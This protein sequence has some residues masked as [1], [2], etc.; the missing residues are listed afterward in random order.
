MEKF[1]IVTEDS[2]LHKEYWQYR[3]WAE[4]AHKKAKEF[5]Q[6]HNIET[7][8]YGLLGQDIYIKPTKKDSSVLK[9]VLCLP[10]RGEDGFCR[11]RNNS[12]I[13]RAWN[14]ILNQNGIKGISKPSAAMYFYSS[15]RI[16]TRL[17]DIDGVLYCSYEN[18]GEVRNPK[19]MIEIPASQFFKVIE[20]EKAKKKSA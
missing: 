16:R 7:K 9:N 4:I 5:L 10:D 12:R 6:S 3:N 1:Y 17:F 15:G 14:E 11:F 18:A 2:E 20:D 13:A 19:G 8:E